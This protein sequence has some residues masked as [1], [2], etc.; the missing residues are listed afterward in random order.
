MS[1]FERMHLLDRIAQRDTIFAFEDFEKTCSMAETDRAVLA[2][3]GTYEESLA[4]LLDYLA[5]HKTPIGFVYS[6]TISG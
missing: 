6:K 3:F 4:E 1:D 5:Q 2:G